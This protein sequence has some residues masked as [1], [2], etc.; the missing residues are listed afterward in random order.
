MEES[1]TEIVIPPA[2]KKQPRCDYCEK[3]LPKRLVTHVNIGQDVPEHKFCSKTC[4]NNWCH[5]HRIN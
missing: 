2:L 5:E 4:K 3:P 1:F